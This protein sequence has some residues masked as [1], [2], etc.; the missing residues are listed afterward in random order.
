MCDPHLCGAWHRERADSDH[1]SQ[2]EL[3][4]AVGLPAWSEELQDQGW[5]PE[6]VGSAGRGRWKASLGAQGA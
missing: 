1:W 5:P 4:I 3:K 2:L 6:E